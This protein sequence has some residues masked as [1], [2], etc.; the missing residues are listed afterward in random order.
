MTEQEVEKV[1]GTWECGTGVGGT[2]SGEVGLFRAETFTEADQKCTA[3][4]KAD[5]CECECE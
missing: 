5:L 2:D 4:F 1:A 3:S